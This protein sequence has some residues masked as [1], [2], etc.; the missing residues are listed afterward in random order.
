M[1]TVAYQ[2]DL[3]RPSFKV[4]ADSQINI[5]ALAQ[6]ALS[7]VIVVFHSVHL[8][9]GTDSVLF[10]LN[11]REIVNVVEGLLNAWQPLSKAYHEFQVRA[12]T[13][14]LLDCPCIWHEDCRSVLLVTNRLFTPTLDHFPFLDLH[15]HK[16]T[17]VSRVDYPLLIVPF[18]CNDLTYADSTVFKRIYSLT[19]S[20]YKLFRSVKIDFVWSAVIDRNNI[21]VDEVKQLLC[22]SAC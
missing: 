10:R 5:K 6:Y 15:S 22:L 9:V 17:L 3:I 20:V 12:I 1:L 13:H 4:L 19:I 14:R 16:A 18:R 11:D 7:P 2:I 21:V 8:V